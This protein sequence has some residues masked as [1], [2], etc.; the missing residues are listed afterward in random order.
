MEVVSMKSL[1]K[2]KCENASLFF[3]IKAILNGTV[4]NKELTK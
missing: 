4:A 3:I 1:I 2:K